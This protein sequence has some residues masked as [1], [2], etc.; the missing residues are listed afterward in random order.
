MI[1]FVD[2]L[3]LELQALKVL[4]Q[5]GVLPWHSSTLWNNVE[6]TRGTDLVERPNWTSA[7]T[8]ERQ[9]KMKKKHICACTGDHIVLK[10]KTRKNIVKSHTLDYKKNIEDIL[11]T[12]FLKIQK[13]KQ[14][15]QFTNIFLYL[16]FTR[17]WPDTI[18][19]LGHSTCVLSHILSSYLM[20]DICYPF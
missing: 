10:K 12:I 11:I 14:R 15:K 4:P 13:K 18:L 6:L 2:L 16:K 20:P 7:A 19:K 9:E 5:E 3:T 17:M 8:L 1:N